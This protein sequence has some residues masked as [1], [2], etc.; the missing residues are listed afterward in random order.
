M[1]FGDLVQMTSS[2]T[3]FDVGFVM[4]GQNPAQVRLQLSRWVSDRKLI[5]LHKGLYTLAEP[6]RKSPFEP[7]V[8][9]NKLKTPSYVSLQS[10]LAF[11]GMIPEFV[12]QVTS[13]TTVRPGTVQTPLGP[14]DFRHIH[15]KYFYGYDRIELSAGQSASVARP[16][17][18]LLDLFYLTPRSD[19]KAFIEQ[20]R[21]QNVEIVNRS[22]LRELAETAAS[23]K[24]ERAV[25]LIE[26]QFDL[27]EGRLL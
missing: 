11:Y 12:P 24:L 26:A 1:K 15:K 20:L 14:F 18:A 10:A 23:P 9:A 6:Y 5:R 27:S 3:C 16:E 22:I 13:V 17:K 21:L 25:R 2:L 19:S 7:F 4:A 8:A